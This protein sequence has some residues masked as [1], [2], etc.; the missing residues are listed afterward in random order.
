[1]IMSGLKYFRIKF[2]YFGSC[3]DLG[4][5]LGA[6]GLSNFCRQALQKELA[7]T[8]LFETQLAETEFAESELFQTELAETELFQT[9]LAESEL[10]QTELAEYGLFQTELASNRACPT[11]KGVV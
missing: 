10:F 1:M 7:E 5:Y 9:E 6:P 8:E 11:L 2:C 4:E 3:N